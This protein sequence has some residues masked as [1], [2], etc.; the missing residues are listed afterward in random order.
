MSGTVLSACLELGL[1]HGCVAGFLDLSM[2]GASVCQEEEGWE[3]K[4]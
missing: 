1:G 4:V 2:H 3:D